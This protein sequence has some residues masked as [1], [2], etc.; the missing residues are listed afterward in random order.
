[1]TTA[2]VI[3]PNPGA[4]APSVL[5]QAGPRLL[6]PVRPA[7]AIVD[8]PARNR[9]DLRH[10]APA[11]RRA[12]SPR[13]SQQ[14]R[15]AETAPAYDSGPFAR[16]GETASSPFVAQLLAQQTASGEPVLAEHRDGPALVSGTYRKAGGDPPLYS[17]GPAI[18]RFSA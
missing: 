11:D 6:P 5:R 17:P 10:G 7:E 4:T 15:E 12:G 1:M 3:V 2:L 18:F 14:R 9:H 8:A 16:R 13:D